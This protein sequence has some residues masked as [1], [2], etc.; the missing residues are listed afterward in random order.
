MTRTIIPQAQ[1]TQ[2]AA[3]PSSRR[4]KLRWHV[5]ILVVRIALL[6]LRHRRHESMRLWINAAVRI[7][8][9]FLNK[10]ITL[11]KNNLH[12]VYGTLLT[13]R[14]QRVLTRLSLEQFLL[15]C[16]ESIIE[17]VDDRILFEGDGISALLQRPPGQGAIV[18]CLHLG[19]WDLGLR[20]LSRRL[21]NV[22]V[23]YRPMPNPKADQLL[24]DARSANSHCHWISKTDTRAMLAWL[25]RGGTLVVMSDLHGRHNSVEV[26]VL[27][28][29]T[30]ISAGP[31]RLS[32][33]TGCPIFPGAHGRDDD[34]RF[35]V[36]VGRPIAAP[37]GP[38]GPQLQAQALCLWQE[39]WI[40]RYCE[41][42]LWIYRHWRQQEGERLRAPVAP[43]PRVM[44]LL[45]R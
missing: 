31:F 37:A 17:P 21:E 18:A 9:V 15:S 14:Q 42:Y 25:H 38:D 36:H 13:P 30:Q 3:L 32:Q 27:G 8:S 45:P 12:K 10:E 34:G 6:L 35:R 16:L 41:Q 23:I 44:R 7:S 11:G 2:S 5:Q 43:E 40:H 39:P 22:A 28:L 24:N 19:C 33:K 20:E 29:S 4:R 1:H 26:D